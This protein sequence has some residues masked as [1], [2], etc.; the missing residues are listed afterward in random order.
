VFFGSLTDQAYTLEV[1]DSTTEVMKSY[2]SPG[3]MCGNGDTA[4]F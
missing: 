2:T 4:A 3:A 1:T